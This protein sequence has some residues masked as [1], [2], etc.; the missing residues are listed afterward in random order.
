MYRQIGVFPYFRYTYRR[1]FPLYTGSIFSRLWVKA[2]L[3]HN[4]SN[5][6]FAD[7]NAFRFKGFLDFP[8]TVTIDIFAMNPRGFTLQDTKFE[9]S[10][11]ICLYPCV[12][13]SS[14]ILFDMQKI[15]HFK[16][17]SIGYSGSFLLV[18]FLLS[19]LIH[20]PQAAW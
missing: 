15:P 8:T 5:L 14:R 9:I 3:F 12:F 6:P 4:S 2:V 11:L 1:F 17:I 20:R 16:F 7:E 19:S 10:N 13:S 18:V